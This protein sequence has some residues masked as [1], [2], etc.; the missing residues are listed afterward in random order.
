MPISA[1]HA[2]TTWFSLLRIFSHRRNKRSAR[3]SLV[4]RVCVDYR[5]PRNCDIFYPA[6][7]TSTSCPLHASRR[8]AR[9]AQSDE[10]TAMEESTLYK[11]LKVGEAK[12]LMSSSMGAAP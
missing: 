7:L 12:Q 5:L 1:L 10:P 4:P 11:T 6:E 8:F 2:T 3:K 9:L